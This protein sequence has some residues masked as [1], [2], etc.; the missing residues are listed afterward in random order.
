M[1]QVVFKLPSG[2]GGLAAM[3]ASKA[4]KHD[5]EVW[6]KL[7]GIPY[8]AYSEKGYIYIAE[9]ARDRDATWF[10]LTWQGVKYDTI[11]KV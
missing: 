3:F 5:L 6:R 7:Y 1:Y 9:L 11:R 2:A 10:A 4:I 8:K